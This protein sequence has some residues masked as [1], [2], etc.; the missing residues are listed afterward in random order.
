M[1]ANEASKIAHEEGLGSIEFQF[2]IAQNT[3]KPFEVGYVCQSSRRELFCKRTSHSGPDGFYLCN[4]F[5]PLAQKHG[6]DPV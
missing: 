4:D 6:F 1:T 5:R 2:N 3:G